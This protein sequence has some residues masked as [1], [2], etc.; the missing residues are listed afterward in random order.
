MSP[1]K[2]AVYSCAAELIIYLEK[3]FAEY[4]DEFERR[5]NRGENKCS[6]KKPENFHKK[7]KKIH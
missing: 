6:H 7:Y 2:E 3:L 1:E 4:F 5:F